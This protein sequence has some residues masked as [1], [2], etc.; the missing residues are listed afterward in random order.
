MKLI[1]VSTKSHPGMFA[2]VDDA[3]FA[4]LNQWKWAAE[5]RNR[6]FYAT[7]GVRIGARRS[8]V[9]MH[10]AIMGGSAN[11]DHRDG[12]GLN[13]QRSNLRFASVSQNG[14]NTT[15]SRGRS[16]FKGVCWAANSRAWVA[17]IRFEGKSTNLGYYDREEAAAL[18]YNIAALERHGE[19][20]KI[21]DGLTITKEEML[22][23]R[24]KPNRGE[25]SASA[26]L[27]RESALAIRRAT[28]RQHVIASAF[29][30]SQSLVSL[31]KLGK[32]WADL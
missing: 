22:A 3:D 20:A 19:F 25:D 14:A 11:V 17:T 15:K 2:Q 6:T 31:I 10:R 24:R 12:N 23:D 9:R 27:S 28:G 29:G 18:A 13:N 16:R 26:K 21:N 1:D 32:A 7:R 8:V 30:V 5:K 4:Y